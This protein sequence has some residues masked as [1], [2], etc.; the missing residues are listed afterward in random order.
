MAERVYRLLKYGQEY[1][2]QSQEAYEA[3]YQAAAGE[4]VGEEGGE[5]GLQAG[6]GDGG[7]VSPPLSASTAH[8]AAPTSSQHEAE[9]RRTAAGRGKLLGAGGRREI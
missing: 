5:S 8:D 2:R 7:S 4:S 6:A 3:A 1:V 9:A